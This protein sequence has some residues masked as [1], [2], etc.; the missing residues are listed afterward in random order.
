MTNKTKTKLILIAGLFSLA[1]G[2]WLLHMR[3]HPLG[4][5]PFNA[6]PFIAGIISILI[7]PAM[8][9]S[10]RTVQ[11]AYVINGILVIIGTITMAH[12]SIARLKV[13]SSGDILFNTTFPD[14]L[15][16]WA[17]FSLG[18]ALF[19][20]EFFPPDAVRSGMFLRYPNM[21]WWFVHLITMSSVYAAGVF[22]W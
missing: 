15:I 11:Y 6:V 14:I 22:L 9:A 12:F 3:V 7:L 8:F 16:L 5:K 13:L 21:G 17:R 18:K 19:D 2:G 10:R 1:L 4:D 20:L